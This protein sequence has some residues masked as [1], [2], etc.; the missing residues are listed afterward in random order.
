MHCI[1]YSWDGRV[2]RERNKNK[3]KKKERQSEEGRRHSPSIASSLEAILTTMDYL[4]LLLALSQKFPFVGL[5]TWKAIMSNVSLSFMVICKK[6]KFNT[7]FTFYIQLLMI[8]CKTHQSIKVLTTTL[9]WF[10]FLFLFNN[11]ASASAS[12]N[13]SLWLLLK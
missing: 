9:I 8:K 1:R 13:G 2:K 11:N 4:M 12:I 5:L 10:F 7:I 3:K 6:K